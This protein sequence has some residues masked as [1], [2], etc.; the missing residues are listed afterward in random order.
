[1]KKLIFTIILGSMLA[2]G[3]NAQIQKGN[4]MMGATLSDISL[5]LDKPNL[6]QLNINPKAAW[7]IQDGLAL[8]GEVQLGIATQKGSGTTVTYGVGAL[9]RY[10]GM[11][12]A[13]E[14]VNNSRFFGEATVGVQG[15]NPAGGGST[16]G[17]GFS[18]GP[19][20]SY[21]V[22]KTIGLEALLKYNGVVGFGSSTYSNYLGLGVGFQIY[23]PGKST[24][25]K[26]GRDMK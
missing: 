21:F 15:I 12:G 13:D 11:G 2:F 26:V 16:N 25:K 19:G 10:Y 23:L 7:F 6:F 4:V 24:A 1:M 22:T 18:F 3:A 9:G 14:V 20:F 8:G 17:L 5:G